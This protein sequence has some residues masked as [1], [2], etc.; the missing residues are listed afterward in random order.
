MPI[1]IFIATLPIITFPFK[2]LFFPIFFF[3]FLSPTQ[4]K[5]PYNL[6]VLSQW[7][8]RFFIFQQSTKRTLTNKTMVFVYIEICNWTWLVRFEIL[9]KTRR[10]ATKGGKCAFQRR[11]KSERQGSG[12]DALSRIFAGS[13]MHWARLVTSTRTPISWC[14]ARATPDVTSPAPWRC[15]PHPAVSHSPSLRAKL[16]QIAT[17]TPSTT[18]FSADLGRHFYFPPKQ[19]LPSQT[20]LL[21]LAPNLGARITLSIP[22]SSSLL[23]KNLLL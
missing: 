17:S 18:S 8:K 3:T 13:F 1:T 20:T 14:G 10:S 5:V 6:N 15:V 22:L 2:L 11:W 12:S 21:T 7:K 4:T 16:G 23:Y 9:G 19:T